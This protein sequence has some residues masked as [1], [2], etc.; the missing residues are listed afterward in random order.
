M[1]R[2]VR[3]M[4]PWRGKP[5]TPQAELALFNPV[6]QGGAGRLLTR[7]SFNGIYLAAACKLGRSVEKLETGTHV[8]KT[9]AVT[10]EIPGGVRMIASFQPRIQTKQTKKQIND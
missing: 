5:L 9:S 10:L 8:L 1:E 7:D 3:V 6:G 2:L 4:E